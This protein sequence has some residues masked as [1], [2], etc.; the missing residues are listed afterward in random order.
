MLTSEQL[1]RL[2][3]ECDIEL[4]VP[5]DTAEAL[6][7][8]ADRLHRRAAAIVMEDLTANDGELV[9][10]R[11]VSILDRIAMAIGVEV[12]EDVLPGQLLGLYCPFLAAILLHC[13]LRASVRGPTQAHEVSHAHRPTAP[14]DEIWYLALA[15]LVPNSVVE[16][17]GGRPIRESSLVQACPWHVPHWAATKRAALLRRINGEA[18]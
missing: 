7:R 3:L 4:R 18:A 8:I 10:T 1:A 13:S 14:H 16:A 5:P 12:K 2:R 17:L 9:P 15:I 6:E 11:F